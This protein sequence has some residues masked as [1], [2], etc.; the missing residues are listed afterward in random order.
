MTLDKAVVFA[1]KVRAL[2][3]EHAFEFDGARIPVTVSMGVAELVARDAAPDALVRRADGRLYE[4]K[5]A[6][7]NCVCA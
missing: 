3:A 5:R 2:V 4:A 1:E 6:G 7:R